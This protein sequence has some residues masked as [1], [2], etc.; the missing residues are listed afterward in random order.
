MI[1][2]ADHNLGDAADPGIFRNLCSR[3]IAIYSGNLRTQL[4]CQPQIIPQPPEIFA[5]ELPGFGRFHKQGCK[6]AVERLCHPAAV[7]STL[8]LEGEL[9][10]HTRICSPA[11]AAVS[12]PRFWAFLLSR[13][14]V[15]R[16]AISRSAARLSRTK[17]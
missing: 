13:S 10:R 9:D 4:F 6:T 3:V 15:R 8:G 7:R 5:G 2:A 16:S 11:L 14:A 1:G 17:K 12:L